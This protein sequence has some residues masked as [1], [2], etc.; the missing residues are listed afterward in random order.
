MRREER[1]R[2]LPQA[3]PYRPVVVR[4]GANGSADVP[5]D[6]AMAHTAPGVLH[7]AVSV[8][9]V[10]AATGRWL[11]QRR[12]ATKPVFADRWSNTC[13]THPVPGEDPA[14]AA[15]RRL[16]QETGLVVGDLLPAG[17]FTYRAVDS[18]SG[19]VEHEHDFV[20]VAV[21]DAG[22]VEPDPDEISELAVLPYDHAIGVL[23]SDAGAPW[24]AAVLRLSFAAL[25]LGLPDPAVP[26]PP[27]G[28]TVTSSDSR[29]E[30]Q[31]PCAT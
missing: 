29:K 14:G 16:R 2:P 9:V 7:L 22:A 3:G 20:F 23:E 6:R 15:R 11:L 21:G 19:F 13:C 28:V 10:D 25:G 5:V 30:G 31:R 24:A 17:S 27:T 26:G 12:A 1:N 4:L 8:Q 18:S